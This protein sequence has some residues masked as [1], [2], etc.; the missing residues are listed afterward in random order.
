M[1]DLVCSFIC[2][3]DG[4]TVEA[5]STENRQRIQIT[6]EELSRIGL[7]VLG[8]AMKELEMKIGVEG[9]LIGD[10]KESDMVGL[11]TFYD[12]LKDSAKLALWCLA[13]KGVEE[14]VVT[15]D[16]LS[17]ALRIC[18]EV[19]ISTTHI[20][21]GPELELL[22]WLTLALSMKPSKKTIVLARL[23]PTQ[24][25]QMVQALQNGDHVVGFLGDGINDPLA[26]ETA[27]VGISV[28]HEVI[29]SRSVD[30]YQQKI[31]LYW[32]SLTTYENFV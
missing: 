5:L 7:Q 1:M 10:S 13:K 26:L 28:D 19:G 22:D 3:S 6:R 17:L 23:T 4:S 30:C 27:N 16:S 25:Q 15:G 29:F 14:K 24:K 2:H 11:M 9:K 8:V 20:I 12:P 21:T 31:N 18:E 32:H